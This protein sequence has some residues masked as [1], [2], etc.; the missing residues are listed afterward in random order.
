M[1]RESADAYL[2]DGCGRCDKYRTPACKV[3][4]WTEPLSALRALA[5]ASG[6]V[7][8]MKW[9]APC[10][11]LDG[12]NVLAIGAFV[13][14]CALSFFKGAG[15]DDPLGALE[16]PGANS[17]HVRFLRFRSREEVEA[18]SALAAEFIAQAI[19]LERAGYRVV[20]PETAEPLPEELEQRLDAEPALRAAF[21]ALTPGR[22]R[23][24]A[25]HVSGAKQ[26]ETRAR[27]AERCVEDILAGRGF[28]ERPE[29]C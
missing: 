6:L 7:E 28:N 27:R 5:Q 20:R 9:G 23:S 15:L 19:A 14:A 24:H 13:D 2:R 11:T 17:H 21:E 1:N 22:R 3:L 8:E 25:L 16:S 12:K 26:S 29:R 18:R 4:R 10:Y